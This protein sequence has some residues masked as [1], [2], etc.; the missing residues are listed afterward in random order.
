MTISDETKIVGGGKK[1]EYASTQNLEGGMAQ[2][3]G[4]TFL[5]FAFFS[6]IP[7]KNC[8]RIITLSKSHKPLKSI[9]LPIKCPLFSFLMLPFNS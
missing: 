5:G 2:R 8:L 4:M 7:F 3:T 1:Q 9:L 6:K